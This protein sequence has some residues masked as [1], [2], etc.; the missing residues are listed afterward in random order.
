MFPMDSGRLLQALLW[1]RLGWKRSMEI[2]TTIGLVAAV[3]LGLF[4]VTSQAF[5]LFGIA[6]FGGITCYVEKQRLRMMGGPFG[7]APEEE[8]PWAASLRDEP[9]AAP[10]KRQLAQQRKAQ[11]Q[12]EAERRAKEAETAE[13]DRILAKIKNSGMGS[14]TR[15][16]ETFLRRTN[17][18]MNK[19]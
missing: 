4:A 18:K 12:A 15:T 3:G 8:S 17:E 1:R 13:L 7:N 9:A 14:L 19:P 2:A 16:E 5:V 11:A 10:S 6:L